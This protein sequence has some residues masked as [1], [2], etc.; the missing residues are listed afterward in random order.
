LRNL[1]E[2]DKYRT[3]NPFG[4][5]GEKAGTFK[6]FVQGRSFLVIA[7]VDNCGPYGLWEHI[8][9]SPKNQKRCPTWDEM[10]AIKDM[11]FLPEEE[12]VQFHPKHSE[13]VNL[14][15]FCLHIWRPVDGSLR[16]PSSISE[17]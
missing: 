2:L 16:Q 4:W 17:V 14:H 5:N 7:S 11:F 6:V 12:C 1:K 13:Y 3:P 10:A 8:S 9:V 15:E